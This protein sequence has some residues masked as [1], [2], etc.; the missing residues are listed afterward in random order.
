MVCFILCP[1]LLKILIENR[2]LIDGATFYYENY[3]QKISLFLEDRLM[4]RQFQK[5]YKQVDIQNLK[6]HSLEITLPLRDRQV[7]VVGESQCFQHGTIQDFVS[8]CI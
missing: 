5:I 8:I 4:L 2:L 1:L 3:G 6:K 7:A